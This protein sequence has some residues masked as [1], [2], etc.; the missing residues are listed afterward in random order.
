MSRTLYPPQSPADVA[1]LV[2]IH[3][4]RWLIP[5]ACLT[6]L[7]AVYALLKGNTWEAT[8]ALMVR[9]EA[10]GK[11]AAPGK[12]SG[13]TEMKLTQETI[14]EVL[15]SRAVLA[16]ALRDVGP[17]A[18]HQSGGASATS[19]RAGGRWPTVE[20]VAELAGQIKLV[21]PKGAEF[22]TTE[23]LYLHV[24][25]RSRS[26]ALDLARALC[27]RLQSRLAALR[28]KKAQSMIAELEQ[29]VRV[30]RADLSQASRELGALESEVG[31]DLSELRVLHE[32]TSPDSDLRR[33]LVEL[34]NELRQARLAHRNNEELLQLLIE[35]QQDASKL[36]ATPNRLL[37]S[38]PALRRLKDGLVDAQLRTA[39]LLGSMSQRHPQVQAALAA[40]AEVR[41]HLHEELE[42]AIRGL[43]VEL[44]LS[45]DRSNALHAQLEALRS[46]LN[47]LAALR[48]PY[49]NL[50]AEVRNRVRLLEEAERN[51]AEARA[52]LAA[53]HAASQV[54]QVEDPHLGTQ[55]VGPSR[56]MIILGGGVA[57]LVA[58]LGLLF[59]TLP[60]GPHAGSVPAQARTSAVDVPDPVDWPAAQ[61]A[62][63]YA[64]QQQR[65]GR[66]IHEP[67]A[68]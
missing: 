61:P 32:S 42:A 46:R 7:A 16:G 28:H 67:A 53:A 38:Q 54:T 13:L 68:T 60:F 17:P 10:A 29:Q 2:M 44:R 19:G 24:R 36:L 37:E 56:A 18:S 65:T 43:E 48:T 45:S 64:A 34:E 40:E 41:E 12:F 6:A 58:G 4:R 20:D 15:K 47:R 21:P 26:R 63:S 59:V 27:R 5:A 9:D 39:S 1:R 62:A 23:I 33:R 30:A 25:D 57:G 35:A 31:S 50:V 14:L 8:Q 3:Y 66:R 51:L 55:P 22:G 11:L 52:S 49:A